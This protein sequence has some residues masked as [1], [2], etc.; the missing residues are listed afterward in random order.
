MNAIK[1]VNL[2]GSLNS[3]GRKER[4]LGVAGYK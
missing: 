4:F 3:L 2:E 1:E